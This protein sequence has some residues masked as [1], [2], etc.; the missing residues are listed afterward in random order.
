MEKEKNIIKMGNQN[1]KG[2]FIMDIS[3]KEKDIL[4]ENQN[5]K[6]NIYLIQNGVEKDLIKM[7]I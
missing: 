5:M 1:L 3:L 6:E 7:V 2:N 4:M